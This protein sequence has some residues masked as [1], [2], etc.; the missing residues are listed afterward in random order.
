MDF[1]DLVGEHLFSGF[2]CVPHIKTDNESSWDSYGDD[3]LVCIDGLNYLITEDL[4]DEWRSRM[5]EPEITTRKIRNTFP[6]Q[7][8]I[9]KHRTKNKDWQG[10]DDDVL[11]LYSMNGDLILEIG[12]ANISDWYPSAICNFMP[13]SMEINKLLEK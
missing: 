1:K 12:T 8:V 7:K 13:E 10:E 5:T 6:E 2:D 11:E 4:C 9:I 3:C